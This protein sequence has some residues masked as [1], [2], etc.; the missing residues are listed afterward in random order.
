[1]SYDFTGLS[2]LL[3]DD[4]RHMRVLVRRLLNA[5]GIS[6][7][8]EASDG[9]AAWADLFRAMPDVVLLDFAMEPI[10]GIEFTRRIRAAPDS[11]NPYLPIIMMTGYTEKARVVEA[12]DAGV[13]E[14]VA[15]P[16]S[17]L[18]LYNRL[19]AVVERPRPF[20]RSSDFFGPDRRRR[21]AP[22][23]GPDRRVAQSG[24][25]PAGRPAATGARSADAPGAG[26][27]RDD[28][29]EI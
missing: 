6:K 20:V 14:L 8:S 25:G 29:L 26:G 7:I 22:F 12:R 3:V 15:K 23:K 2:L 21:Q 10:D 24:L 28:F 9:G 16:V 17:A 18:S 5:F 11:P 19:V 4:N 1:M 13:T 27:P